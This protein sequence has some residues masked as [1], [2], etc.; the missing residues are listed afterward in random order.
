[1]NTIEQQ[2]WDYIDGT[3]DEAAKKALEAKIAADPEIKVQYEALLKLN[4]VLGTLDLDEPSMSF[5]R[6]VMESIA[7]EPAPVALKTKVNTR[8]IYAIGG[9]F[10]L[11]LLGILGYL[12]YQTKA[13]FTG[14]T[15]PEKFNINL[16]SY[17]TPTTLYVFLFVDLV[18]GLIFLD[19]F[20]RRKVHK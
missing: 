2:L 7:L 1:M 19:Q 4:S 3:L 16:D 9:F 8:I 12:F 18:I 15:M 10:V 17:I 14:F 5:T 20:L 6:N 13:S 11:S